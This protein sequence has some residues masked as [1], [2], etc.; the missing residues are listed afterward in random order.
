MP[1][2]TLAPGPA[3]PAGPGA[4]VPLGMGILGGMPGYI[5]GQIGGTIGGQ[6][7]RLFGRG[8]GA[9]LGKVGGPL[10]VL[11][12]GLVGAGAA[13]GIGNVLGQ[14]SPVQDELIA[15]DTLK[16]SLGDV[17]VS[18]DHLKNSIRA[19]ATGL[20]LT[21]AAAQQM[22]VEFTRISGIYG[23]QSRILDQQVQVAG[24]FARAYGLDPLAATRFF[25]QAQFRGVTDDDRDQ[26]RLAIYIA[27]AMGQVG[28]F[29]H[30]QKML[31]AIVNFMDQQTP[32]G[33][34]RPNVEGFL[35]QA[36]GLMNLRLPGLGAAG[37]GALL[38]QVNQAIMRGGH[39]GE[40]GQAFM[41]RLGGMLG[42]DPVQTMMLQ[43]GGAFGTVRDLS[44]FREGVGL[45][46]LA[47]AT[48][49]MA[50]KPLAQLVLQQL[51]DTHAGVPFGLK[52]DAAARFFGTGHRQAAA[53]LQADP[54]DIGDVHRRLERIGIDPME[55]QIP[56]LIRLVE[57]VGDPTK[58]DAEIRQMAFAPQQGTLGYETRESRVA[59][60][61]LYTEIAG[62]LIPSLNA[63]R[64]SVVS[65]SEVVG[66]L[67]EQPGQTVA[68][69]AGY[70]AER[71][72]QAVAQANRP[73]V[74]GAGNL[75]RRFGEFLGIEPHPD[76]YRLEQNRRGLQRQGGGQGGG[77]NARERLQH[78]RLG[79]GER[80]LEVR[81]IMEA[82][83]RLIGAPPGTAEAQAFVESSWN[84]S[85]VGA[86]GERG[87]TQF[88]PRTWEYMEQKL[89]RDMDPENP[90]HAAIMQ[91]KYLLH[92]RR[93]FGSYYEAI[94]AYNAGGDRRNWNPEYLAKV[95]RNRPY[96][97]EE[98]PHSP[99]GPQPGVQ[100][101]EVHLTGEL[102]ATDSSGREY[103]RVVLQPS[104]IQVPD[105]R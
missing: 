93:R 33:L 40:P 104:R 82:T 11:A 18:F 60:Q 74:E 101:L 6:M 12:G 41:F 17:G 58:T 80:A 97:A 77:M 27:T 94:L 37:A 95:H 68:G 29:P 50:D 67:I 48:G 53:L 14:V 47:A 31:D 76:A 84:P 96:Y 10:G 102:K 56:N 75:G 89:G 5:G 9:L 28:Q 3:S 2:G 90:V 73:I 46:P 7:G 52:I 105:P 43:E 19:T 85:A 39:V 42:L 8:A 99:Q 83:D 81:R 66:K 98:L 70:L 44:R 51:R 26:R 21:F 71:A 59:L 79:G 103:G 49:P 65:A 55:V 86:A 54:A 38:G 15:Y 16:R 62:N 78:S 64:N 30:M 4:R 63:L 61:N 87:L 91:Q 92:L 57:A 69:A 13:V 36:T 22:A 88:M 45:A 100:T 20:D 25:A 24:G 72:D 34:A 32:V 23:A 35:A 1:S